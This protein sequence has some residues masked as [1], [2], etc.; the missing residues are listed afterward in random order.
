MTEVHLSRSTRESLTALRTAIEKAGEAGDRMAS[1]V[2]ISQATDGPAAYFSSQALTQQAADLNRILEKIGQGLQVMRAADQGLTSIDKAAQV[3]KSTVEQA[4]ASENAFDRADLVARYNTLL[5][6]ISE[7][8]ADSGYQGRNLL[9]GEGNDLKLYF[10]DA[11]TNAIE[12]KAVDYT[13]VLG[14]LDLEP[15]AVGHIGTLEVDLSLG[16]VPSTDSRLVADAAN[17]TEGD[18]LTVTNEAG[19]TVA[20]LTVTGDTTVSDLLKEFR[21]PELGLRASFEDGRLKIET[22]ETMTI[23]GGTVGGAFENAQIDA[24]KSAWYTRGDVDDAGVPGDETRTDM[25]GSLVRATAALTTIREQAAAYGTN[26]ALLQNRESF[27]KGFAG[28]LKMGAE[29]VVAADRSEE[30][31]SLL[32]LNV[33]QQFATNALTFTTEADQGVLRL[34]GG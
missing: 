1:G 24:I 34:L 7:I 27:M 11:Q 10:S 5:E 2:K 32:S 28:T 25:P 20:S 21:K 4:Q 6:Q 14:A 23:T 15:L 30:A 9:G 13:D 16:L 31:A 12:V 33:R 3:V 8:A 17:F 26:F 19:D 29:E 18:V 22:A